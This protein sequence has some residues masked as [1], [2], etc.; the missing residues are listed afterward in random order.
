VG[1]DLGNRS[2]VRFLDA[3][4]L[5]VIREIKTPLGAAYLGISTEVQFAFGLPGTFTA[6]GALLVMSLS[7]P[8]EPDDVFVVDVPT[9]V[10]GAARADVRPGLD[11][12]R[13]LEASLVSVPAF[14]GQSIPVNVYLPR[15]A[16]GRVP[17]IVMFHGGPDQ[18]SAFEWTP[19]TQIFT[20]FGFAVIEPNIRGS[21]GFGRA[22]E[23]GDD[24][25][26]RVDAMKDVASVNA[27]ARAQP[28]CAGDKLVVAGGSYGGYVVLMALS[29]QPEL[30]A[31]GVD[32]AGI[33]DLTTF[34]EAD[35]SARRYLTEFGDPR[36]PE[37]KQLLADFS[38]LADVDQ[39]VDPL[40]VYQGQN[41]DR[42]PRD[43]ADAMV[44]ALR[45]RGRTVEY[46]VAPDEGHTL[47]RRA[48]QLEF[49]SR[50]L[51]F[52]A[53]ALQPAARN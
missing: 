22:W 24:R 26:R 11:Q 33:T 8:S 29:R 14:D 2:V 28:W 37:G 10:I 53:D 5:A 44:A 19:V 9:G 49:Y 48:N 17:T 45:K 39:I 15:G 47:S 46:M 16:Q 30:W 36:T 51:R 21:T 12:L 18:S 31:A 1:V 34:V 35:A 4:T 32:L 52:L 43:Q 7:L 42:V 13:G 6:D 38:P 41:D 50:V 25:E 3:G 27:W 40:F 23:M 20:S